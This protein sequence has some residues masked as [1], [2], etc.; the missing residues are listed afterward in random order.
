MAEPAQ[1][2]DDEHDL[3]EKAVRLLHSRRATWWFRIVSRTGVAY[4][5]TV[6]A[7]LFILG[8]ISTARH[9][10]EIPE[11][12]VRHLVWLPIP[13]ALAFGIYSFRTLKDP[14]PPKERLPR[15]KWRGNANEEASVLA[16]GVFFTTWLSLL[17]IWNRVIENILDR[18]FSLPS[19]LHT[20]MPWLLLVAPLALAVW[21]FIA[22]R[23][24]QL[25]I[26]ENAPPPELRL[27]IDLTRRA[28]AF[29][30][31]ALALEKAMEE[32]TSISEQVQRG[33]ELEQQQLSE[34]HEQ[35]LRKARA[36]EQLTPEVKAAVA[37]L[38]G[39]E[40]ARS[41]QRARRSNVIVAFVSGFVF[42]ALGVFTPV[43]VTTDALRDQIRQW[44]HLG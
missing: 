23:N 9:Q 15:K 24:Q 5:V 40:Q 27:A 11:Y 20:L 33:I 18:F 38:L 35:Y 16:L 2:H 19:W 22:R 13:I 4:F 10:P 17:L 7:S 30:D 6:F 34:V 1:T 36:T 12:Q 32:A 31:R 26:L 42:Y 39:A 8:I 41:E 29:R 21:A 37:E 44:L 43:F 28:E 3:R 25:E 14:K